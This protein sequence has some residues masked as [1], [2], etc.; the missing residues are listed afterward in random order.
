MQKKR[1]AKLDGEAEYA[2]ETYYENTVDG[3]A[4]YGQVPMVLNVSQA[5]DSRYRRL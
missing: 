2:E 5:S 4:E 1:I 3:E